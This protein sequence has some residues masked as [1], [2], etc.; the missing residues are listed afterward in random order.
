LRS[1]R[2]HVEQ[3]QATT[4]R[5]DML[6]IAVLGGGNGSFAAARDFTLS[7]HEVRLWRRDPAEVKA[8]RDQG[9]TIS[10]VGRSGRREARLAMVTSSIAEAI[11]AADLILCPAPAFAQP[12]HRRIGRAAFARRP[13]PVSASRHIRLLHLRPRR[14]QRL[15]VFASALRAMGL[16]R[17]PVA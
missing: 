1:D 16:A 6:K 10:V 9:G 7:G 11:E 12:R 15:A 4:N 3:R 17:A 8:H 13:G 2:T 5:E 14:E